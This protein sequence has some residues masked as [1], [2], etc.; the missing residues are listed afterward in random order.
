M[1]A[2]ADDGEGDEVEVEADHEH[3]GGH[4]LWRGITKVVMLSLNLRSPGALGDIL[5][6]IREQKYPIS[7]GGFCRSELLEWYERTES[8][9]RSTRRMKTPG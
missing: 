4:A 9:S 2:A 1:D 5:T 6:N 8:W 7:L 3:R